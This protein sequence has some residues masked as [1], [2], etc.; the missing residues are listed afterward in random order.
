MCLNRLDADFQALG[1]FPIF[2]TRPDELQDLCSRLVRASGRFRLGMILVVL[3]NSLH[4]R[5]L[6]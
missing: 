3:C 2:K 1:D 5:P 6:I 4:V